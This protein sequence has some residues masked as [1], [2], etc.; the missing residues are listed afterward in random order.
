MKVFPIL[1]TLVAIGGPAAAQ[2]LDHVATVSGSFDSTEARR[3]GAARYVALTPLLYSTDP[4]VEVLDLDTQKV[5]MVFTTR[6]LLVRKYGRA[7]PV[8]DERIPP[9]GTLVRYEPDV[10]GLLLS[11]GIGRPR[12]RC[13]YAE[14]DASTGAVLRSKKL[15]TLDAEELLEPIGTDLASGV[16]WFLRRS[17]DAQGDRRLVLQRLDL[18][19]LAVT[20]AVAVTIPGRGAPTAYDGTLMVRAAPDFS[21][22][23]IAEYDEI[24]LG[25][26]PKAQVHVLDPAAGTAFAIDAL[27]T[28]YGLVFTPDGKHLFL[29]SSER[30]TVERVDLAAG[31]VDW[32]VPGP[33]FLHH[34]VVSPDGRHLFALASSRQYTV[35]DLAD[36]DK[37][38]SVR[39][40]RALAPAMAELFGG[41]FVTA[42][43][44][45]VVAEPGGG[46]AI[47]KFD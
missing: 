27:P 42:D 10:I 11:D 19:K 37:R 8:L 38:A 40:D 39:H 44:R 14:F 6:A 2:R 12:R 18:A 34:L 13:W 3:V 30:G 46:A 4:H 1:V 35:Y 29:G 43:G 41:G 28:N 15:W 26:S 23:A 31:R 16:A 21:R 5:D 47:G 22:F 7:D 25:L 32:R 36:L 17:L 33:R 9:T 24:G 20:D 45:F